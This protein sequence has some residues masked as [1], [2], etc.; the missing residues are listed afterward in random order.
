MAAVPVELV[1][2]ARRLGEAHDVADLGDVSIKDAGTLRVKRSGAPLAGLS[3]DD[4]VELDRAKLDTVLETGFPRDAQPRVELF[5]KMLLAA[6]LNSGGGGG[7]AMPIVDALVH[8]LLPGRV[9]V[10]LHPETLCAV[11]CCGSGQYLTKAW[12]KKHDVPVVWLERVEEGVVLAKALAK[13]LHKSKRPPIDAAVLVSNGGVYLQAE[14]PAG[15][16][17]ALEALLATLADQ[18]VEQEVTAPEEMAAAEPGRLDAYAAAL[19]SATGA[20]ATATDASPAVRALLSR[21]SVR[22]AA[23]RGPIWPDQVV[24]CG[25]YPCHVEDDSGDAAAALEPALAEHVEENDEP[26]Q[27][28]LVRPHGL[29]ATGPTPAAAAAAAEVFAAAAGVYVR[30]ERMGVTRIVPAKDRRA[31]EE[32]PWTAERRAAAAAAG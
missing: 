20:A 13:A 22:D 16:E 10:H 28:L 31:L 27:V 21:P 2:T 15:V 19:A 17:A 11:T 3:V 14:E 30:S 6:R 29:V 24:H 12:F 9:V 7:D 5:E 8:H 26:P 25:S 18:L 23:L 32:S 1:E 4:F